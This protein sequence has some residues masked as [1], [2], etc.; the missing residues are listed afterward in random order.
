MNISFDVESSNPML[1]GHTA[2][3]QVTLFTLKLYQT[4]LPISTPL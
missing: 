3:V 1:N 2:A 4:L